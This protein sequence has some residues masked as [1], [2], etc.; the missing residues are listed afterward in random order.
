MIFPI[1]W[2]MK[3]EVFL[4]NPPEKQV[5]MMIDGVPA[6]GP[7]IFTKRTLLNHWIL[8]TFLG[9]HIVRQTWFHR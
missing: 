8:M 7:S 9:Y 3:K 5:S 6:P 4:Q 1:G 2:L